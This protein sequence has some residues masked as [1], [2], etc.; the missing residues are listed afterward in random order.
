M[1]KVAILVFSVLFALMVSLVVAAPARENKEAKKKELEA[2]WADL[3]LDDPTATTAVLKL[4]KQPAHAV[5]FLREKLR[6]LKLSAARCRQL[7]KHL[8]SNDEKTWKAA[9]DELDYLDPRLAIDLPT[10]MNEVTANPART[11][12]VELCSGRKADSLLGEDVRLSRVG[13]DGY[14]FRSKGAWWAEHRIDRIGKS[15]WNLKRAW[16]RAARAIALL[17]QIG[18]A[19]AKTILEQMATGHADAFPTKAAKESLKRLK[20]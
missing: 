16:T 8:G 19:E 17:E 10:L 1:R 7:L 4:F 15:Y 2:L 9:W 18:T 14:N 20:K 11:R 13:D 5:P 6:P 3:S 12:M